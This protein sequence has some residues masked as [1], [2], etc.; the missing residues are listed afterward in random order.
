M[1]FYQ[2]TRKQPGLVNGKT[3]EARLSQPSIFIQLL[4]SRHDLLVH[5]TASRMFQRRGLICD[6]DVHMVMSR[7]GTTTLY[8][9][10]SA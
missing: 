2:Y 7:R 10:R 1:D 9:A 3:E 6:K 8:R 5:E 4:S